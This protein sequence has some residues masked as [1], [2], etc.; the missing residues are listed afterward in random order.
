MPPNSRC[1]YCKTTLS[2]SGRGRR[3]EVCKATDCR[4]K[5]KSER[6]A[7][8]IAKQANQSAEAEHSEPREDAF[9]EA[10]YSAPWGATF[11]SAF[12]ALES[13]MELLITGPT[14]DADVYDERFAALQ[15]DPMFTARI[16]NDRSAAMRDYAMGNR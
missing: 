3:P 14:R 16:E 8:W 4:K 5:A 2:Y 1:R 13:V 10:R 7:R 15:N 11:N 6:N 9:S 12:D